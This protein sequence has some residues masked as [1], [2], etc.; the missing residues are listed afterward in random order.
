M[1][2]PI[3]ASFAAWKEASARN[4]RS[5]RLWVALGFPE[6]QLWMNDFEESEDAEEKYS[7][8]FTACTENNHKWE[9]TQCA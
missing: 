3:R 1:R 9:A 5:P 4:C 7:E 6:L 2:R 8:P